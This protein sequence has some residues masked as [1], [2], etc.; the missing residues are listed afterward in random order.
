MM[1]PMRQQMTILQKS[2]I[3]NDLVISVTILSY[4]SRTLDIS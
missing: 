2:L 4:R 3:T 1:D